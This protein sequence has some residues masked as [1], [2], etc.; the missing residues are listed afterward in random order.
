[1]EN[2]SYYLFE[3][4]LGT[5]GLVVSFIALTIAIAWYVWESLI[6]YKVLV[7]RQYKN[8]WMAWK[9]YLCYFALADTT[10]DGKEKTKVLNLFNIPTWL[11]L[12]YWI[13]L[14]AFDFF[15][16]VPFI[17]NFIIYITVSVIF[18]G[19]IYAKLFA[20]YDD[21]PESEKMA[22][23]IFA[24]VVNIV[25]IA[26]MTGWRLERVQES[27]KIQDSDTRVEDVPI[28][29][30]EKAV[31]KFGK[32]DGEK[33]EYLRITMIALS[34][35]LIVIIIVAF[36]KGDTTPFSLE[37][38]DEETINSV[39]SDYNYESLSAKEQLIL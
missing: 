29:E 25:G 38:F 21:V 1:M 17:Y 31:K 37:E 13:I 23:G 22:L 27:K 34:V 30:K 8:S 33:S 36:T 9:P 19:S 10:K 24:G 7:A 16:K 35:V 11:Y 18:R 14:I 3:Q 2:S 26:I 4:L 15:I 20:W 12:F 5:V 28:S 6:M 39:L 32:T